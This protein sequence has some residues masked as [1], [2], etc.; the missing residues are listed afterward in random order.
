MEDIKG[1][2]MQIDRQKIYEDKLKEIVSK[3]DYPKNTIIKLKIFCNIDSR[4]YFLKVKI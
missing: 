2:K 1:K 4:Y 3:R